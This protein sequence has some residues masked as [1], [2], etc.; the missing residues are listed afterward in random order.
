MKRERVNDRQAETKPVVKS[1]SW[2]TKT[3]AES[4]FVIVLDEDDGMGRGVIVQDEHCEE[5]EQKAVDQFKADNDLGDLDEVAAGFRAVAS[6]DA[7]S[8]AQ[9]MREMQLPQPNV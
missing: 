2:K 6:F 8:L 4:F 1:S 5:A 7:E 3:Q 9:I